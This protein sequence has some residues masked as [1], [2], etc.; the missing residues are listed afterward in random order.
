MATNVVPFRNIGLSRTDAR[1]LS[2]FTKTVGK[3]LVGTEVDEA[4]EWCTIYR[5]DPFTRDIYFFVFGKPGTDERRVVPVLSIGLYRKIA[6]RTGDYRPD[7][8]PPRFEYS[9]AARSPANPTGLISAEV[10]VNQY[11]HGA[12]HP[13][14]SRL[15]WS[16]RAPIMVEGAFK[17][18]D[19][20][21]IWP[22]S[23][24][25]KRKKV[26]IGDGSA[27][28][29]PAK[30]NWHT[31]PETMLA[32]C[33]EADAIRKG[34]PEDTAGSYADGELD[35]AHTLELT[36][37][38]IVAKHDAADRLTKIGGANVI[39]VQW[40]P[41]APLERV[42]VGKFGD[43]VL[44]WIG[45][46]MIKGNEEPGAVMEWANRNRVAIREYWAHDKDGALALKAK[47]EQVQSFADEQMSAQ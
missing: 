26:P 45:A 22:D 2:L 36:A 5:A 23:G 25:P 29:D 43:R 18:E 47:L 21:E 12:W 38:E 14:T 42:P 33:V 16:E 44:D 11:K 3:E 4:I 10:T 15:K 1:K 6:S 32:K 7:E 35:A 28:L 37:T 9:D 24:K 40:D 30:K 17:W 20:G 31:M 39:M 13:I 46:H 19:T 41:S 27:V 8:H 34:W